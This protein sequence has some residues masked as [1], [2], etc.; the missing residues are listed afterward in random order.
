MALDPELQRLVDSG[1]LR[2]ISTRDGIYEFVIDSLA[3]DEATSIGKQRI[4][5]RVSFDEVT[6]GEGDEPFRYE[7]T[8]ETEYYGGREEL[9]TNDADEVVAW[10]EQNVA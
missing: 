2:H 10:I 9:S 7:V 5:Y 6:S 1:T 4:I 3:H 8:R